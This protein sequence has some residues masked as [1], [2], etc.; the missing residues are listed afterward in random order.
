LNENKRL[1]Q[2]DKDAIRYRNAERF[3]GLRPQ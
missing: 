3:Y 1:T 2:E